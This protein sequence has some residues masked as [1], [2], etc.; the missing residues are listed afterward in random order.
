MCFVLA[1]V[2]LF[3]SGRPNFNSHLQCWEPNPPEQFV[4]DLAILPPHPRLRLNDSRI[5]VLNQT[6]NQ[7][8]TAQAYFRGLVQVGE[9][10]LGTKVVNCSKGADMLGV[11]RT[12]LSRE[13][14]LG[15]LWRLTGDTRFASRAVD[16]LLQVTTNCSSW[17]PFGLVLAEMTHAVA[18]GFDWLYDYLSASQKNT[19][20]TGVTRLGF[21]EALVQYA[22]KV[23]WTNC[24][25]NWGVVT[26]G[27]LMVGALAFL[28][29]PA[30]SANASAVFARAA[31]GV[32]CPFQSFSPH[33]A[34]HEGPMYWQYVAEYAQALTVSVVWNAIYHIH[35]YIWSP[36][37]LM[38]MA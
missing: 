29:E 5:A 21:N 11:A 19:I 10:L 13:Y 20:I 32:R 4:N 16:E 38:R 36:L 2:L 3:A 1:T 30:A 12:V 24:T 9:S 28:D 23:F 6:I 17:D 26:N 15:L 34:W 25:F 27:G 7:D 31:V 8:A 35:S 33:G 22:D 18:I 37:L 14:N